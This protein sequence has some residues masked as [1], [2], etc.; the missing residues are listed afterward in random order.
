MVIVRHARGADLPALALI[1]AQS[2]PDPW[3]EEAL[4]GYLADPGAIVLIAEGPPALGFLIARLERTIGRSPA[5]HIHD[6]AVDPAHRRKGVGRALVRELCRWG[7]RTRVSRVILEVR[8]RN[9]VA[10]RFYQSLGFKVTAAVPGYYEDGE[11]ALR[12]E[13]DLSPPS[14]LDS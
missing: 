12:M 11:G 7:L 8:A 9:E 14:S 3:P 13:L 4:A 10:Q 1:E 2:F 5:L 6:L